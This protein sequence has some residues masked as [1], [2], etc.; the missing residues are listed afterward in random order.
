LP[1]AL[2]LVGFVAFACVIPAQAD[3]FYHLRSG[4]EIWDSSSL[5][6]TEHFSWTQYGK[7]SPN[8]WWLTQVIFYALYQLGGPFLLTVFAGGLALLAVIITWRLTRGSDDLRVVLL[9]TL[10]V[11]LPEWS[12]RTQVFSLLLMA[13]S[14][15]LMARG[16]VVL[17]VLA[18]VLWA[19]LHAVVV[20]G[21]GIA[22]VPLMEAVLFD[23]QRIR[24]GLA[25]TMGATA[26]PL[27]T[28]LGLQYWPTLIS[29]VR[30]S[31]AIGLHEYRSAFE[32]DPMTLMFWMVVGV[33]LAGTIRARTRIGTLDSQS[34]RLILASLVLVP[35]A[36]ASVR[37]VPFFVLA[38]VPALSR[39]YVTETSSRPRPASMTARFMV[40]TSVVVAIA[41]V[42]WQWSDG[43]RRVG[44]RPMTS[45]AIA[46]VAA[47]PERIYNGLNDGE[48]LIWFVPSRP[49]FMDGRVELYPVD[50]LLRGRAADLNAD[51]RAL[52][53]D[54]NI[55]CAIVRPQSPLF[56][57]LAEDRSLN[58]F[59]KDEQWAV[60]RR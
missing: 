44:W 26:A 1:A 45:A 42:S 4:R 32:I 24:R 27:L 12:V 39:L 17:L 59:F 54:Y 52:F 2:L 60:F 23:R 21:I 25:V 57:A 22:G 53:D 58:L 40:I 34:R 28:P 51:Y 37:N 7:S 33:L 36:V 3:T 47:C 38:A 49:V 50:L 10:T 5:S 55:D 43:G 8:H 14:L 30:G 18:L 15:K 46:A 19:N 31:R 29:T 56:M 16:H 41:I 35:M 6:P 20:L 13:V 9:M 48:Y 11:T